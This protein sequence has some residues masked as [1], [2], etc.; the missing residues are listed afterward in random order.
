M[1]ESRPVPR[2]VPSSLIENFITAKD[3]AARLGLKT[4]TLAKWRQLGKGPHGW[5]RISDTVVIYPITEV[6]KFLA[7][8][9]DASHRSATGKPVFERKE[10]PK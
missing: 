10:E 7:D 4:C 8:R 5:I 9:A 6:Q 2:L 3:L 1:S